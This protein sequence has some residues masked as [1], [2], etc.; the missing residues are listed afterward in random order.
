MEATYTG[1]PLNGSIDYEIELSKTISPYAT[2]VRLNDMQVTRQ[3]VGG[4]IAP[5]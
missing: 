5:N 1:S 2:A 3:S 4:V